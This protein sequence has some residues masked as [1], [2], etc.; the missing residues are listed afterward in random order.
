VKLS[1]TENV[2]KWVAAL[3]SGEYRQTQ[4]A[5][6]KSD[7]SRCC[8]GVAR[9]LMEDKSN[10]DAYGAVGE[11][12]GVPEGSSRYSYGGCDEFVQLNDH[13]NKSFAEIADY[14]EKECL[15]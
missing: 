13:D 12:L 15:E 11:W 2:K 1:N 14:V 4:H 7:G 3:R 10:A 8:L 6:H 9:M 5:M